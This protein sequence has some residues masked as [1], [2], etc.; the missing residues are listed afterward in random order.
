MYLSAMLADLMDSTHI[1]DLS[2]LSSADNVKPRSPPGARSTSIIKGP[3]AFCLD[4][5]MTTFIT[6]KNAE[7]GRKYLPFPAI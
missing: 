1:V 6:A 7:F 3:E 4:S 5:I 2:W